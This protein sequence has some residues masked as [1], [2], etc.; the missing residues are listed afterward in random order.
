MDNQNYEQPQT[1]PQQPVQQVPQAPE[2]QYQQPEVAQV[3]ESNTGTTL[4]IISLCLYFGV[5]V[6][7]GILSSIFSSG[8]ITDADDG[9]AVVG[10]LLSG[11]SYIAAWVLAIVA[12][13]KY[14]SNFGKVLIIVYAVLLALLVIA[15]ILLV[16]MCYTMC[17]NCQID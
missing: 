17:N 14:K 6:L 9:V 11:S 2:Y 3:S 16:V 5:P 15:A 7:A 8:D 10:S 1:Q 4:C 12:R 13:V